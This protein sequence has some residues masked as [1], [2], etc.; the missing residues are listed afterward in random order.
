MA[1]DLWLIRFWGLKQIAVLK[2]VESNT[3]GAGGKSGADVQLGPYIAFLLLPPV[4]RWLVDDSAM[5]V[6]QFLNSWALARLR[7][8]TSLSQMA[9]ARSTADALDSQ[10]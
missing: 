1:L 7:G 8:A 10:G 2:S 3:S 9:R 4:G 5:T 6:L